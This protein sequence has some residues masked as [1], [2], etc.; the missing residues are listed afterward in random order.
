MKKNFR[1][2]TKVFEEFFASKPSINQKA[3]GLINDFYNII[4]TYM[5]LKNISKAKLQKKPV[6]PVLQFHKCLIKLPT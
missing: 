6:N 4:L 5:D 2:T 3:W 1:N